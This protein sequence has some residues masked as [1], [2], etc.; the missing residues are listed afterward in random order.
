M[1]QQPGQGFVPGGGIDLSPLVENARRASTPGADGL[2]R[3]AGGAPNGGQVVDV[4]SI[5]MD[6]SDST[7]PQIAQLSQVVPVV[8]HLGSERSPD[9]VALGPVLEAAV[10]AAGGRLVLANVD[11]EAN[12]GL[13]QAFQV[14]SIPSAVA[15]VA[16]QPVP[17]FQGAMAAPQIQELFGQL[18]ELAAQQGVT[19]AVSAPDLGEAAAAPVEKPLPP[20]HQEAYDAIERGDYA[21]AVTA[22]EQ[23]MQQNPRDDDARAGLAQVSLLL[24]LQGKTLDAIR[25]R[26]AAEPETLEAQLDVADLDISGGHIEDG[27]VRLLELFAD[28]SGDEQ[29]LVRERLVELFEVVGHADPRVVAAR[30]R[31]ATLLY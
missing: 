27:F 9:S 12:P 29:V 11:A 5:V 8:V 28:R 10:R 6:I 13:T 4:P 20:K 15:L 3:D 2:S 25:A 16:G 23:A 17:L 22:Y 14:Q 30:R 18:L 21:A 1:N 26:A 24:R 19:G 7:F 31:L